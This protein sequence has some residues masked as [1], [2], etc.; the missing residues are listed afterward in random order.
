MRAFDARLSRLE[1]QFRSLLDV[2]L[3]ACFFRFLLQRTGFAVRAAF[4]ALALGTQDA[5][6]DIRN[7]MSR[8]CE[9]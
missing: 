2:P 4:D 7:V 8:A 9:A 3:A 1:L 6:F 5:R